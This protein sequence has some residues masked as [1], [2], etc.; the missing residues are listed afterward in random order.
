MTLTS[1]T[2]FA[3][4]EGANDAARWFW[5]VRSVNGRGLDVRMR[6]PAGLEGLEMRAREAI[7]KRFVRGSISASLT[8]RRDSS[9]VDV[10]INEDALSQVIR[11]AERIATTVKTTDMRPE[12]LL[13]LK[14]VLETVEPDETAEEREGLAARIIATLETALDGVAAARGAEGARLTAALGAHIERIAELVGDVRHASVRALGAIKARLEEQVRRLLDSASGLDPQR[15]H[16]EAVLLATRSDIEEEMKRLE[17]HVA[18]ARDLLKRSDAAGRRLDFLMQEFNREVNTIC[19]KAFDGEIS[20]L[21]LELKVVI[22][23]MREQVQN[24]E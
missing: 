6:L 19:S 4:A 16:Q 18:A 9:Q 11:A 21:G 14:G 20:K 24:I 15:L 22:D 1:M 13:A 10:R 5:E 2:G 3:R 7:S 8:L 17:T 12:G 23:Q